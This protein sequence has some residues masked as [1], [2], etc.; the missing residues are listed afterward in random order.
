MI[1]T[2][3]LTRLPRCSIERAFRALDGSDD[4]EPAVALWDAG[5]LGVDPVC[6]PCLDTSLDWADDNGTGEPIALTWL[7]TEG[8]LWCAR[9]DW[10][11]RLC[12]DWRHGPGHN[13]FGQHWLDVMPPLVGDWATPRIAR[14]ITVP[15]RMVGG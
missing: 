7:T 12:R 13:L 9:H 2:E 15:R 1:K 14:L 5:P 8:R 6:R 10:P 4:H 3:I 11:A